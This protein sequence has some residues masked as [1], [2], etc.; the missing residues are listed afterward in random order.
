MR[1]NIHQLGQVETPGSDVDVVCFT[2]R[3]EGKQADEVDQVSTRSSFWWHEHVITDPQYNTQ[4]I[5]YLVGQQVGF[6]RGTVPI[7]LFRQAVGLPVTVLRRVGSLDGLG[8]LF[9]AAG[10]MISW[11]ARWFKHRQWPKPYV[12]EQVMQVLRVLSKSHY[13]MMILHFQSL[14]SRCF[15]NDTTLSYCLCPLKNNEKTFSVMSHH[16]LI[17]FSSQVHWSL[18][19]LVSQSSDYPAYFSM[20][21]HWVWALGNCFGNLIQY[22]NIQYTKISK[23][24]KS[25]GHY[26]SFE[27]T[28][29]IPKVVSLFSIYA[30]L[31]CFLFRI[32][33]SLEQFNNGQQ[34]VHETYNPGL[35]LCCT[36]VLALAD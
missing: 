12:W 11:N 19:E 1:K 7:G 24:L 22:W 30:V 35:F 16:F 36:G 31:L 21:T 34:G 9:L 25:I 5:L 14:Q 23:N 29:R 3:D 15:V 26:N 13:R 28:E 4:Y 18:K 2:K 32:F 6:Y 10:G 17:A 20:E 27:N 33:S 8:K